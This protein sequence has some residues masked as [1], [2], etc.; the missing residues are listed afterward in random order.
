MAFLF[1]A[2]KLYD[3]RAV[4][5]RVGGVRI[6]GSGPDD[7]ISFEAQGQRM[8]SDLGGDGFVPYNRKHDYRLRCTISVMDGTRSCQV[9][10]DLQEAQ[11]RAQD[12]SFQLGDTTFSLE[13]LSLGDKVDGQCVFMDWSV[14]SKGA[15]MGVR[16]FMVELPYG[17]LS[18]RRG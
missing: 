15:S 18:I 11:Q 10:L 8:E 1:E 13:D 5:L 12:E 7:F 6:T 4:I 16:E 14:P 2:A 9:L 17:S 3:L